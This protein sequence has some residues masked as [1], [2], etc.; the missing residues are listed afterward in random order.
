MR[1]FEEMQSIEEFLV[2]LAERK[3]HLRFEGGKLHCSAPAGTMSAELQSALTDRKAELLAILDPANRGTAEA[4]PDLVRVA[5]DGA[6]PL[7]PGQE[8]IWAL[9]DMRP[10]TSMYNAATVFRLE[11]PLDASALERSL[12]AI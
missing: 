7:S 10:G 4:E 9:D 6:L 1:I 5:R 11:G 8:R 12:S 3:I 2:E